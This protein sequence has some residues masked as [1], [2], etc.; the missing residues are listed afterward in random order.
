M[1]ASAPLVTVVVPSFNEDPHIVRACLESIRTQTFADFECIVVDESTYPELAEACRAICAEDSRFIYVHPTERL[2]LPKSLNLAISK[3]RGQLIARFDS[4]DI[5]MP[6]R[7]AL[8]VTFLQAHPEISVVGG[9]LDIISNEGK[10]LAHR[11]Y[12]QTSTA[13]AKC[14]QLTTAIAHPTVMYRKVAIE[15]H[16]GY[17]PD[18]RF[19]E[20]LDLWLR[21]M[22][23]GL[24]F[25][26]LPQVLVQY[27]QDN[28][29]RDQSHWRFNLRART[30]NFSNQHS[31]RRVIGIACIAT[32]VAIPKKAQEQIFKA[33]VLRRR[34]R[35]QEVTQ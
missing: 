28:T 27:R 21:W 18:F 3:A 16:G 15:R 20:D 11:Y 1:S 6:E 4:D 23:A 35:C 24:L 32:W 34:R 14:M 30:S 13:I 2:G 33:L 25:A 17:N 9:A 26:N 29:R 12:P 7:L 8:Q 5:C 22:N 31:I 10:F 19:A